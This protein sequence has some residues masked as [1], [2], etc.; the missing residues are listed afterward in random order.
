MNSDLNIYGAARPTPGLHGSATGRP[1]SNPRAGGPGYA[2][3]SA[4]FAVVLLVAAILKF[5]AWWSGVA[6]AFEATGWRDVWPAVVVVVEASLAGWLL[7]GWMPARARSTSIGLVLLFAVVAAWRWVGGY[8]DCGCFGVVRVHPALTLAL[9]LTLAAAL[10]RTPV[11]AQFGAADTRRRPVG[12][13]LRTV[14]V[15]GAVAFALARGLTLASAEFGTS[16]GVAVVVLEPET[17]VGKPLPIADQIVAD[18]DIVPPIT[19]GVWVIVFYH[20]SCPE[21]RATL[22]RVVAA[23]TQDATGSDPAA[24]RYLLVETNASV[25]A[26]AGNVALGKTCL[27]ARLNGERTWLVR[28]PSVV[29]LSAGI[30]ERVSERFP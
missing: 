10:W 9:D 6:G 8:E 11:P 15:A 7:S 16:G 29:W 24:R 17:W 25:S 23:A 3:L 4:L 30:V 26:P 18:A 27:H 20:G 13:T 5:E 2:T 14:A 28:T 21:C 22:A 1:P 19:Q 12:R